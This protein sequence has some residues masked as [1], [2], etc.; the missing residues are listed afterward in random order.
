VPSLND[1]ILLPIRLLPRA[2]GALY[3]TSLIRPVRPDRLMRMAIAP[4]RLGMGLATLVAVAASRDPKQRAI[5]DELGVL[6]YGELDRRSARIA[7]GM[8]EDF[9]I[10]P[11][12]GLAVMCRN[13]RGFVEA[14]VAASRCGA[15]LL[16][17]NTEIPGAQLGPVIERSRP[18]AI[19]HDEE[20]AAAFDEAGVTSDRIVAWHEANRPEPTLDGLAS[21]AGERVPSS[22][23]QGKLV[24]LTSGTTG[25]PKSAPRSPSGNAIVG[26]ATTLLSEVPFRAREPISVGPPLFH[27]FGFAFLG[28][29]LFLGSTIVLRRK[30]D[31]EAML[32][33][34]EEHGV[35][36]V[37]AVPAML[38]R[39]LQLPERVV[40]RYDT[41]SL[42]VVISAAAPLSGWLSTALMDR[43]GDILFNIYGTTEVG[44]GS[45]ATPADLRAAP[46]TA[47]RPPLG[48]TLE[49]LDEDRAE[50]PRRESGH[51][52]IGSDLVFE[53][54]SDG[55]SKE[56]VR[57]LMNT[58]DL[59]HLDDEGR[60]FIDGREDDMIVSGGENVFP[61]EVEDVLRAHEG[62]AD[63]AVVGV[64]DPE[65]GQRLQAFVVKSEAGE[66]DERDLRDHVR[67]KLERYKVPR[68]FVFIEDLPRNATGKLVR[69]R[70]PSAPNP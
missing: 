29:G 34:I 17:V 39:I 67:A 49:I 1:R 5:V 58:G 6:T 14:A 16:S 21:R 20:F 23:R 36:T 48:I 33:T 37:V 25:T 35:T 38:Q 13:H 8:R 45:I 15:D 9:G 68:E 52:F 57:G 24:L 42:R 32:T 60:L 43:F 66:L 55:R 11:N 63:V 70:L 44:F 12:R 31:P 7:A 26:P 51:V 4:L 3:S 46:G 69:S 2:A 61:Q 22:R 47:G 28:L 30:F 56:T 59:G 54:Y 10:G 64:E 40:N 65:F 50:L 62:V 19:V 27:G 53:G 41:S 18:A